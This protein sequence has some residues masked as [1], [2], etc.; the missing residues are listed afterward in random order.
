MPDG[1]EVSSLGSDHLLVKGLATGPGMP[2]GA[3]VLGGVAKTGRDG[4]GGWDPKVPT[5][6]EVVDPGREGLAALV[7]N[8]AGD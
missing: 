4:G 3:W 8:H 2:K 1:E 6:T 5:K 7:S